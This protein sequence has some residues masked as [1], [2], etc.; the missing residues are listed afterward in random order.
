MT[1]EGRYK[2]KLITSMKSII[3]LTFSYNESTGVRTVSF[4]VEYWMFNRTQTRLLYGYNGGKYLA[5]GQS[6]V[7]C[8]S[9]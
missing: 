4:Y 8:V 6:I 7:S 5:S 2:L 3:N 9:H 1:K